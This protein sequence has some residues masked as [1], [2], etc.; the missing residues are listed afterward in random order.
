MKITADV[1]LP[2]MLVEASQ[3]EASPSKRTLK[4]KQP[5]SLNDKVK[6]SGAQTKLSKFK[7]HTKNTA[8]TKRPSKKATSA[9][10][11]WSDY[12]YENNLNSEALT[13]GMYSMYAH[14]IYIEDYYNICDL[15][16]RF[17]KA[18]G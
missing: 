8:R 9:D 1:V 17:L 18:M 6:K 10:V 12:T 13:E 7:R 2:E 3:L 14:R 4:R 5:R 15:T 16:L 11:D